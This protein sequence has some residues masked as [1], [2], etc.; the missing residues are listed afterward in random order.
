MS[1]EDDVK[2]FEKKAL[3]LL[4]RT[5]KAA[6]IELGNRIILDTPV[7]DPDSWKTKYPPKGYV[8]GR[9]RGNWI[10]TINQTTNF[11]REAKGFHESNSNLVS[12]VRRTKLEDTIVIQN[13][14]PYIERLEDGYSWQQAPNGMVKKNITAMGNIVRQKASNPI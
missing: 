12:A 5:K 4:N 9:A 10:T 1:F 3:K 8:G 14:L 11:E 7:G 2:K 6:A 13:N